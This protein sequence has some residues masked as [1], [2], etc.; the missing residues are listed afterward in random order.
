MLPTNPGANHRLRL[1][2][3]LSTR[4]HGIIASPEHRLPVHGHYNSPVFIFVP[5]DI[6]MNMI[7]QD[8]QC[9]HTAEELKTLVSGD[10]GLRG[11]NIMQTNTLGRK[12]HRGSPA[13]TEI[14]AV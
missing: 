8:A 14:G 2:H 6:I 3:A 13:Q 5:V 9:Q 7:L 1:R 4:S 12:P 10:I 11:P